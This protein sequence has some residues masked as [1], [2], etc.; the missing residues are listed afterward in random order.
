M[1]H[2]VSKPSHRL[3]WLEVVELVELPHLDLPVCIGRVRKPPR[4]LERFLARLHSDQCIACNQLLG[5]AK[6]PST[7]VRFPPAY[8]TRQPF[9]LGWSPEASSSTPA[10]CSCW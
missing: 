6:G 8:L 9:A 2:D 7:M 10:S 4:P 5:L 1:A 3:T